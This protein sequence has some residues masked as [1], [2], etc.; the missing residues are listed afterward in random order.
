[1]NIKTNMGSQLG[2][3][4]VW[5]DWSRGQ[6]GSRDSGGQIGSRWEQGPDWGL[7]WSGQMGAGARLGDWGQVR[8]GD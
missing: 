5:P 1:M 4:G 6:I 7:G 2:G 8:E 3:W